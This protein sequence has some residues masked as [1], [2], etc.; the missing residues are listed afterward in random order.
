MRVS[1]RFRFL[2]NLLHRVGLTN[3]IIAYTNNLLG[4][5]NDNSNL[6]L[7]KD[8][9]YIL[10]FV[11]RWLRYLRAF[12][13][14]MYVIIMRERIVASR[15]PIIRMNGATVNSVRELRYLGMIIGDAAI[16]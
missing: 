5:I 16:W 15:W 13:S 12:V 8:I 7:E 14:K 9:C 11:D 10:G 3:R 6:E 2:N 4:L 1:T